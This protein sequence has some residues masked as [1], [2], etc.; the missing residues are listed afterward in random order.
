MRCCISLREVQQ[1][2]TGKA[3]GVYRTWMALLRRC[4][5]LARNATRTAVCSRAAAHTCMLMHCDLLGEEAAEGVAVLDL[6][7]GKQIIGGALSKP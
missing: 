5:C 2:T 3:G 4:C 6:V 7:W 1:H